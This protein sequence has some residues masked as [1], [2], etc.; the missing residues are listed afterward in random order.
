[1]APCTIGTKQ[2]LRGSS[3]LTAPGFLSHSLFCIVVLLQSTRMRECNDVLKQLRP[4][5]PKDALPWV[6]AAVEASQHG[7]SQPRA[8]NHGQGRS[9]RGS[10][11][12]IIQY[13]HA[14]N[15]GTFHKMLLHSV[16]HW[17]ADALLMRQEARIAN[18]LEAPSRPGVGAS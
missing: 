3:G 5:T 8:N 6:R 1:M 18:G 7:I 10:S 13:T 14:L 15:G 2:R 17:L 12:R 11:Y 16:R 4:R 9:T